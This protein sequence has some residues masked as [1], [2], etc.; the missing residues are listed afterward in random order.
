M[1]FNV[2]LPQFVVA[3]TRNLKISICK[4][5]KFVTSH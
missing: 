2:H 3:P 1:A 5:E 4:I